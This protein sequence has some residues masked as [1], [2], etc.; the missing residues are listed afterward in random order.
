M[1]L[2]ILL[3]ASYFPLHLQHSFQYASAP[4]SQLLTPSP[5]SL[6]LSTS[7]SLPTAAP[8]PLH[9]L[10]LDM[11]SLPCASPL[12]LCPL[13]PFTDMSSLTLFPFPSIFQSLPPTL[14]LTTS[15]HFVPCTPL[16]PA[17]R[18]FGNHGKLFDC[19]RGGSVRHPRQRGGRGKDKRRRTG[20]S[21]A[22][23]GGVR[24]TFYIIP[25]YDDTVFLC[26]V[27]TLSSSH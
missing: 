22:E 10:P 21:G 9:S 3:S 7:P 5:C 14:S 16:S 25:C 24:D 4:S 12:C 1:L 8:S 13:S 6:S 26:G 19:S 27:M 20:W 2:P 23:L 11:Y 18:L 17:S 15:M